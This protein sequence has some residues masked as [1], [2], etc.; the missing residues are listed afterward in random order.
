MA[1][2]HRFL[3]GC[4][5]LLGGVG[6]RL[7]SLISLTMPSLSLQA[8]L[9]IHGILVFVFLSAVEI[10]PLLLLTALLV[11]YVVLAHSKHNSLLSLLISESELWWI[12]LFKRN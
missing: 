8:N 6:T 2:D 10:A 4:V 12:Q 1:V 11:K 7:A 3:A 5:A 9:R